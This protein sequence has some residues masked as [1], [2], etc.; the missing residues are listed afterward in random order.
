MK[1]I[2]GIILAVLGCVVFCS[3]LILC[4][5]ADGATLNTAILIVLIAFA[6]SLAI[7]GWAY[8]VVRLLFSDK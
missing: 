8:L 3:F 5:V 1:K 7:I 2:L 4:L 6:I